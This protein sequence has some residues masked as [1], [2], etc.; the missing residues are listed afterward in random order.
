ML[1]FGGEYTRK[2]YVKLHTL[3][4]IHFND[5]KGDPGK[6]RKSSK[7]GDKMARKHSRAPF[8]IRFL[9]L[10]KGGSSGFLRLEDCGFFVL[11][12]G[13]L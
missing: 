6:A 11:F 12:L 7:F 5:T 1:L 3:H 10:S 4:R 9:P 13:S 2:E 8:P